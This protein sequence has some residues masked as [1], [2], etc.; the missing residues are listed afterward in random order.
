MA[1]CTKCGAQIPDGSMFCP[2]CGV[3]TQGAASAPGG[4]PSPS[5]ATGLS[6]LMAERTAQEYWL[7]RLVA[8]VV[9]AIIVYLVVGII[10]AAAALPAYFT[11]L[12]VPGATANV[13][14]FGGFFAA[15]ANLL[16][17]L[18][19]TVAEAEY[20]KTVGKHF[21]GLHVQTDSGQRPNMG[22]SLLRNVSK[23]YWVLLLLDVV[24]GLALDV[25]YTKKFS[26]KYLGTRVV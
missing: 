15:I 18:Y 12:F 25:G 11:S 8:F 4:S 16:F 19:F 23:I 6:A 7:K 5:P 20:G 2:S 24:V 22:T 3:P 21:M 9:D 10:V 17:V 14:F 26:D 13:S 1:F